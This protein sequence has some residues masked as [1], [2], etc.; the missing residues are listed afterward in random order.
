MCKDVRF[1]TAL[2]PIRVS[3]ARISEVGGRNLNLFLLYRTDTVSLYTARE[4]SNR[5]RA[6]GGPTQINLSIQYEGNRT[7]K[8]I[9]HVGAMPPSSFTLAATAGC[10]TSEHA[11]VIVA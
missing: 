4:T 1:E 7:I 3:D 11:K 9:V 2:R 10:T 6:S 5:D 8:G